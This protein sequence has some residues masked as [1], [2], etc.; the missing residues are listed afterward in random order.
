MIEFVD[1]CSRAG[2]CDGGYHSTGRMSEIELMCLTARFDREK[3][4]QAPG[5]DR[6]RMHLLGMTLIPRASDHGGESKPLKGLYGQ[7]M[8]LIMIEDCHGL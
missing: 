1:F 6:T 2:L 3:S 8:N 5:K 4:Y 7:I